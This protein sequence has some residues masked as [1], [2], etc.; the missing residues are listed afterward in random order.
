MTKPCS[1]KLFVFL[2][3]P[4]ARRATLMAERP[5]VT[6][7]I[8][9]HA[10]REEGDQRSR[11]RSQRCGISIHALREEGDR[12]VV[13]VIFDLIRFLSTPSARRATIDS[14]SYTLNAQFLSTPSA[15]RATFLSR[16][17]KP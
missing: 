15:R 9:I 14:G 17:K 12:S 6:P 3:T 11:G 1:S 10:L 5:W 7:E 4:S 2:S 8:S 16:T 13:E